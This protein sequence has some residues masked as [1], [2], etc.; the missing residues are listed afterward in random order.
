MADWQAVYVKPRTEKKVLERLEKRYTVFCPIKTEKRKWSDRIKLVDTPILPGYVFFQGDESD[1]LAILQDSQ[2]VRS[3]FWNNKPAI[4]IDHEIEA[5]RQLISEYSEFEMRPL[6][7]GEKAKIVGGPLENQAGSI[8]EVKGDKV[9]LRLDS[10]GV[11]L[12][13]RL[14]NVKRL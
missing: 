12:E 14:E 10:L 9:R 1:R 2:V 7:A 5:L 13:A 8:T 3:V 11:V 4:I 6:R